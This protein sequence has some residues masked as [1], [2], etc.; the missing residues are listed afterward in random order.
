MAEHVSSH[1]V[2]SDGLPLGL[3]VYL[4]VVVFKMDQVTLHE[5]ESDQSLPDQLRIHLAWGEED[6]GGLK[7]LN[8][9]SSLLLVQELDET[10]LDKTNN[11]TYLWNIH[12]ELGPIEGL[13]HLLQT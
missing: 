11:S 8:V 5:S 4:P 3:R 6:H 12:E 13:E 7:G 9:D 2:V 10:K 1:I